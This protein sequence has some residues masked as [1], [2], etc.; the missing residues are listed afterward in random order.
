V[1]TNKISYA[2]KALARVTEAIS[3]FLLFADGRLNALMP[4]GQF[5]LFEGLDRPVMRPDQ[6]DAAETLWSSLEDER[7]QYLGGVED[8][9]I[10]QRK[11]TAEGAKPSDSE[12]SAK[13]IR[14]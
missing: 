1:T 9:L 14:L 3:A 10:Q 13:A 8:E 6:L 4:V 7:N 5:Y 2:V 11:R 12:A